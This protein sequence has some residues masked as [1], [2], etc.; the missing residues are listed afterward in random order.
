MIAMTRP[1]LLAVLASVFAMAGAMAQDI[2]AGSAWKS[3]RG[4]ILTILSIDARGAFKGTYE[5]KAK[6]AGFGCQDNKFDASG[7]I[8]RTYVIF[9]VTFKNATANCNMMTVWRGTVSG[10]RLS[11]RWDLAHTN[12]KTGRLRF[13]RGSDTFTRM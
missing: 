9:Y 4:S 10:S 13:Y 2:R 6:A 1:A 5:S 8:T 3:R 11:V 7:K 12:T